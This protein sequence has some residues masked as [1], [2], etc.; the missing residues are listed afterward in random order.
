MEPKRLRK[1]A[2]KRRLDQSEELNHQSPHSPE[3][4]S[5]INRVM[6][7]PLNV[8][9]NDILNLQ[10]GIGNK[11][12]MQLMAQSGQSSGT[13][14][15][16]LQPI[17]GTSSGWFK[18]R[19][20]KLN[21]MVAEYNIKKGK[22]SEELSISDKKEL[23]ETIRKIRLFAQEWRDSVEKSNPD[24]AKEINVWI[25]NVLEPE[26]KVSGSD[27]MDKWLIDPKLSKHFHDF[28]KQEY[29]SENIEAYLA[30]LEYEKNPN[31]EKAIKLYHVYMKQDSEKEINIQRSEP[32]IKELEA[33]L[34]NKKAPLPTNFES[35]KHALALNLSDPFA[36][37]MFTDAYAKE[38]TS[39]N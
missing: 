4:A 15:R 19:R 28:C 36:R 17:E 12:T 16:I 9:H 5:V 30:I 23:K 21:L 10:G 20:D 13:I 33:V 29:N 25:K 37:F 1:K 26:S 34:H 27:V 24:K 14:Q 35:V 18:G 31:R 11:A 8:S 3:V 39:D 2:F 32:V 7:S 6:D 38:T 22:L